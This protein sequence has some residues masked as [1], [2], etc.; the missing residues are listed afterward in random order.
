[1]RLKGKETNITWYEF[2]E[3][4]LREFKEWAEENNFEL[5]RNNFLEFIFSEHY[6]E[7]YEEDSEFLDLEFENFNEWVNQ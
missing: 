4:V 3:D 1:M 5:S 6:I 7:D 2:D